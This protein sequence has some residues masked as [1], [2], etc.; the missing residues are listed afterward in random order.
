MVSL[1]EL[2]TGKE[3]LELI[4]QILLRIDTIARALD[5]TRLDEIVG[6]K[7]SV[8]SLHEQTLELKQEVLTMYTSFSENKKDFD[9]KFSSVNEKFSIMQERFSFIEQVYNDFSSSK[10]ELELIKDF[11][12]ENKP[13]FES[14]KDD[15]S[16]YESMKIDLEAIITEATNNTKL[17]KEYFEL[18]S[19][20][21]DDILRELEHCKD[22]VQELNYSADELRGLKPELLQIKK[23]VNELS[24]Q[25]SKVVLD[26]SETIKNKIN[27]IFFENQRLNQEMI[28]S[29]K[30]LEE[31]KYDIGIKYKEIIQ[32]YNLLLETKESL[33]ELKEVI[34]L[35]KE[36]ENDIKSYSELIKNFKEQIANLESD[37]ENKAQGLHEALEA[38]G[39]QVISSIETAKNEAIVKFDELVAKCEGYKIHFEQSYDRFNQRALIANEDLGRLAEVAKKELG[40][41]KLIYETELKALRDSTI[42]AM[43]DIYQKMCDDATGIVSNIEERESNFREYIE[44]SKALIDNL[45]QI[46]I[47]TYQGYKNEFDVFVNNHLQNLHTQKEEYKQEL[48]VKKEECKVELDA[49]KDECLEEIDAKAI[50][51]DIVSIKEELE[52]ILSLL[53]KDEELTNKEESIKNLEDEI[54]NK[55]EI[56]K[57]LEEKIEQGLSQEPPQD[58]SNLENQKEQ[59]EEELKQAQEELTQKKNE[60]EQILEDKSLVDLKTLNEALALKINKNGDESINGIK[61]FTENA[62]FN[63]E[64]QVKGALRALLDL[65]ITRNLSVTGTTTLN[66]NTTTKVF[67]ATENAVFNKEVQVKGALRALL[68]LII[69][70]NLSVTGTTTL[71]NTLTANGTTNL[72]GNTT[73]KLI[74]NCAV[75]PTADNHLARK[76]YVDY[77]GGIK[78]LGTVGSTNIDLRQA[79][80]FILTANA[81]TELGIAN[82]GGAGKSGTITI[83]NCQNI[84]SF[85]APFKFR[86][87]Q[88][89]FSGTET[90]AYFCIAANNI[91]LVRS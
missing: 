2:K 21:K 50:D 48:D 46:F 68:D 52:Y 79:Q 40:N 43:D 74:P 26:A 38:K 14:L 39:E 37:L 89:G 88:S 62:V 54:K 76:W 45:T 47:T 34:A 20:I 75:N 29:V 31:I 91:R 28:D 17:S 90:F 73:F 19:K 55:E 49:K 53:E 41:D 63:K 30:K 77:G 6:L 33:E 10:E 8:N 86:I 80:H 5:N 23:E 11:I 12:E 51:Y 42:E 32:A 7:E 3:K 64:V 24:S 59:I 35:Y 66:G 85:K 44:T 15:L 84:K 87:A 1:A 82:W 27:T 4:N 16:K 65:I 56:I 57:D 71:N 58:V 18:S 36:F 69:T 13:V 83:N 22:L 81:N 9:T 25:A 78:N 67:T 61:T 60:L 70:R 72:N